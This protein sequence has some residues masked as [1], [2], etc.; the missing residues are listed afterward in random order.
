MSETESGMSFQQRLFL[1]VFLCIGIWMIFDLVFPPPPPVEV[2]GD[3][4]GLIEGT[5][6]TEAEGTGGQGT[7]GPDEPP[8]ETQ[9]PKEVAPAPNADEIDLV[10]HRLANDVLAL[11]V[12]NA[13]WGLISDT[14][15]LS[16][17]FEQGDGSGL[18]FLN[19]GE[20]ATLALDFEP[21]STSFGYQASARQE[22]VE[23]TDRRFVV[24]QLTEQVEVVQTLEL[25]EGYEATYEIALT[26]RTQDEQ[27]HALRVTNYL[28][29][30]EEV[31]SSRYNIHRALC[32]YTDDFEEWEYDDLD[33]GPGV[34]D[35]G[36]RWT[37]LASAYFGQALLPLE[38][39]YGCEVSAA[40]LDRN[41]LQ[42]A[43]VGASHKLGAGETQRIQ[44]AMYLGAKNQDKLQNFSL[45]E[46]AQLENMID[47]GWFGAVSRVLGGLLFD[48]LRWIHGLVGIW[49]VSIII[50]T[51]I[52]KVFTLPLTLKQMNSMKKM[53]EIQPEI[54]KVK[55]K[56][57]DDKVKQSQEMQALFQRTG[58]NPLAGCLPMVVQMPIWFAL[59]SMLSAVVEL[60][61]EP[62]LWLPDLTKPDPF[63][64]LP[65]G[66]GALMFIQTRIQPTAA[67]NQQA[68][69]MQWMMPG[70]FTVMML[71]LPSGLGVYIFAN[72]VLSLIQTFIQLRPGKK[73]ATPAA[74]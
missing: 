66:M 4:D 3:T 70:I 1:T 59:Y 43:L 8:P 49:G 64:V 42:T 67:D 16:H 50:L 19:L 74:S 15:L 62:F 28:G 39:D 17:Q 20:T 72:I 61:A 35:S 23:K 46:G 24:R 68:K 58:V 10:E 5:T 11:Q 34:L 48:L 36:V 13:G 30:P 37:A 57:G 56:Y 65:L 31:D 60:Y 21:R 6:G 73:S 2:E 25:L 26:N 18:D 22:V 54:E 52:I 63:Y 12:S 32:Q 40:R 44:F 38:G 51:A 71:F 33:E 41:Y 27:R 29:E 9:T 7:G 14:E 69:M 47:W 45:V 55:K 53:R